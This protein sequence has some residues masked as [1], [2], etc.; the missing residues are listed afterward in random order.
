MS[1]LFIID[2]LQNDLQHNTGR[3]HALPPSLQVFIAL[4]FYG[5]GSYLDD[6]A[7]EPHG[8]S[9]ATACRA[10]SRVTRAL[11]RHQRR[12]IK[13]P[14]SDADVLNQ[15]VGFMHMRGFPRVIGCIDGTHV[16]LHGVVLGADEHVYVNRKGK[17]NQFIFNTNTKITSL[18][19]SSVHVYIKENLIVH[20]HSCVKNTVKEC[21]M[22]T[23]YKKMNVHEQCMSA[24]MNV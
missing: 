17:L 23:T 2:L 3:N 8:V 24:Y 19:C 11:L 12:F 18:I 5:H 9:I 20:A 22:P 6:A 15:Q 1:C 4:R 16:R 21:R 7:A 10:V 14:A 13:F